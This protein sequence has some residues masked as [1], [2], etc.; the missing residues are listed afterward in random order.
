MKLAKNN[1]SPDTT[2]MQRL[3]SM[4]CEHISETHPMIPAATANNRRFIEGP[5]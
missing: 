1:P 2:G 5:T 4:N 3:S